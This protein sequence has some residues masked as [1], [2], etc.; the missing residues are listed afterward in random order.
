ML[1]F[2]NAIQRARKDC[3]KLNMAS[4]QQSFHL[5]NAFAICTIFPHNSTK[6]F[7]GFSL[8]CEMYLRKGNDAKNSAIRLD[9]PW[10]S[11]EPS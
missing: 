3:K 1:K 2:S 8:L 10:L 6:C 5:L 7:D 4:I 9:F 11:K